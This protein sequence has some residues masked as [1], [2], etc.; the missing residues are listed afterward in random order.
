MEDNTEISLT[1]KY[2]FI[3][4][5]FSLENRKVNFFTKVHEQSS[6]IKNPEIDYKQIIESINELKAASANYLQAVMESNDQLGAKIKDIEEEE[7]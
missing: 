2:N 1:K 4:A 3:E 6:N 5:D 7:A